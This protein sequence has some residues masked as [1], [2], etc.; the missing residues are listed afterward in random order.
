MWAYVN[1][2]SFKSQMR[3]MYKNYG[4][5]KKWASVL[6]KEVCEKYTSENVLNQMANSILSDRLTKLVR[7]KSEEMDIDTL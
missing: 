3:K 7:S 5:Y 6:K 2:T 4:M 1:P